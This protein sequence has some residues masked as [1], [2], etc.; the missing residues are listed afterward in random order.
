MFEV[1]ITV[2]LM[3]P[4]ASLLALMYFEYFLMSLVEIVLTSSWVKWYVEA[5][6]LKVP[7]TSIIAIPLPWYL[8]FFLVL[9]V[10]N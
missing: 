7:L 8:T 4:P 2:I 1:V 5:S 9:Q 10:Y 6:K 3:Y